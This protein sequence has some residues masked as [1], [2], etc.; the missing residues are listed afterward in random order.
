MN[1]EENSKEKPKQHLRHNNERTDLEMI[2]RGKS[3]VWG[4]GTGK[5]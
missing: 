1:K 3:T 5:C 4:R 2:I